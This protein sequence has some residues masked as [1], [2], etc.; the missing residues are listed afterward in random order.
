M[1]GRRTLGVLVLHDVLEQVL[2]LTGEDLSP[3]ELAQQLCRLARA[4][5]LHVLTCAHRRR[6]DR[7]CQHS[8][9]VV[10]VIKAEL[11]IVM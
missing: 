5:L 9:N 7:L 1:C 2:G 3:L 11:L 6:P 10:H 4:H 8:A